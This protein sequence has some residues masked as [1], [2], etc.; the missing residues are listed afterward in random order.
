[1]VPVETLPAFSP[2]PAVQH[3]PNAARRA[4]WLSRRAACS[5]R[6]SGRRP[7][8]WSSSPA[9]RTAEPE[10]EPAIG[11][12]F[13][14]VPMAAARRRSCRAQPRD[15]PSDAW[16][17]APLLVVGSG[18]SAGGPG[19]SGPWSWSWSR[20]RSCCSRWRATRPGGRWAPFPATSAPST[21]RTLSHPARV[22]GD[23]TEA[24][25]SGS[26]AAA[27][28]AQDTVAGL[29]WKWRWRGKLR[30]AASITRATS[31]SARR[32][33]RLA[34]PRSQ[35]CR[36]IVTHLAPAQLHRVQVRE[37]GVHLHLLEREGREGQGTAGRGRPQ[38]HSEALD[39]T[40]SRRPSRTSRLAPS[41]PRARRRSR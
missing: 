29:D 39:S 22:P 34:P 16:P 40:T 17:S 37:L 41:T 14:G 6:A 7:R 25:A 15:L 33:G 3:P 5:G 28:Y 4:R 36:K 13:A 26:L 27:L 21:T 18:T 35:T 9:S 23:E 38:H 32:R 1:M 30:A 12:S 2:N 10:I 24:R 11:R 8:L 19:S 31:S 20:P